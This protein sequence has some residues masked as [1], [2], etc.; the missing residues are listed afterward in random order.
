MADEQQCIFCN[1]AAGKIPAKTVYKD[2]HVTAVLDINPASDG[3]I[4]LI[5]KKHVMLMAQMDDDLVSHVGMVSKQ[6]SHS[7]IRALK[8]DGVSVFAANGPAAG[9]R[10][11]HFM[12][13]II[14]RKKGDEIALAPPA[15]KVDQALN[16]AAYKKLAVS[17]AKLT[18]REPPSFDDRKGE[19]K[20]D[21]K[22]DDKKDE[23]KEDKKDEKREEKKEDKP[24]PKPDGKSDKGS[25]KSSLDE[26]T[27]F[28]MGGKK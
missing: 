26:I 17:L 18:G 27:D 12:L 11:P 28:L 10:A 13:H 4:L 1:I 7:I 24:A 9:Q 21:D 25:F 23:N 20:K 22:K 19:A 6:L 16:T 14:P 8:V 15:V 5:P 2:D 3:H